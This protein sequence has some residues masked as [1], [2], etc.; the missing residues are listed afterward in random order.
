MFGDW[1]SGRKRTSIFLFERRRC[2]IACQENLLFCSGTIG[3]CRNWRKI[4]GNERHVRENNSIADGVPS[5]HLVVQI[6][7]TF[8]STWLLFKNCRDVVTRYDIF[9]FMHTFIHPLMNMNPSFP[10]TFYLYQFKWA[11]MVLCYVVHIIPT[12]TMYFSIDRWVELDVP[13]FVYLVIVCW[14]GESFIFMI[15]LGCPLILTSS[16]FVF[17]VL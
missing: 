17:C 7:S 14:L 2:C 4:S 1:T 8:L 16:C 13:K 15:L 3:H 6:D 12:R 11:W 5:T 10:P 9:S